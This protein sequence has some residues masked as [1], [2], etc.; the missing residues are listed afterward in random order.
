MN[1]VV[2][3]GSGPAGIAAAIYT[4]RAR[5]STAV[6]TGNQIGGQVAL[7]WEIDNYPGFINNPS[8]ADLT[9]QLVKH[10]QKHG[11]EL[12]YDEV[13][14]VDFSGQPLRVFT[15]S[16]EMEAH[17][18]VVAAGASARRLGVPG[19]QEMIGR[20][21]SYCATCDA[22]FFRDRSVIVVGGGDSAVE[23][24]LFL[25]RFASTVR[26]VHRRDQLRASMDLQERLRRHSQVG[27]VWNTVVEEIIGA[28]KVE[29]VRLRRTDTGEERL[30]PTDGVFVFIGHEPN[31][32]L[33]RDHL[34]MDTSGYLKV[35]DRMATNVPGVFAA[36]E[37]MDP[38]WRQVATSVG[39]GSA[40]GLSA[41]R[42]V[43][44]ARP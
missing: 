8:G 9:D 7:T 12:I 31:S 5:L 6:V 20:G 1:D 30:E 4:A 10:A 21:V 14:R 37:V 40:A 35:D 38:V 15:S 27:F 22:P 2:V 34:D 33:F 41:V 28:G 42:Y 16:Q 26:L 23:E 36:G 29:R 13:T 24:S 18:V 39:Q 17:A 44:R 3:I 43:E 19:E 11:A 32:A 25:T